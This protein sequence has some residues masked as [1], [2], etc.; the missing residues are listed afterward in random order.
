VNFLPSKDGKLL[1]FSM[2]FKHKLFFKMKKRLLSI[3]LKLTLIVGIFISS[4]L[5]VDAQS[6]LISFPNN[7]QDVTACY[8]S[9]LLTV[10]L[11]AIVN[12]T[13][14]GDV[15]ISLPNGVEYI[16]NSVTM[17]SG[18]SGISISENGGTLSAPIF[19]INPGTLNIADFIIFT[20]KRVASC[21]SYN[22]VL[23]GEIFFD[24]VTASINGVSNEVDSP[25]YNIKYP[26]LSLEQPVAQNDALL[27]N[28]N[29]AVA[30]TYTRN[31]TITNGAE[32]CTDRIYF[33][34]EYPDA[35]I[36]QITLTLAGNTISPTSISGNTY[37]YQISGTAFG[38]DTQF[39]NGETLVFTETYRIL[40]CNSITNYHA[41]WGCDATPSNWCQTSSGEGI[42]TMADGVPG[43]TGFNTQLIGYVDLCT[44]YV[45]RT[46]YTAGGTGNATASSL[47]DVQLR[48]GRY[49][50]DYYLLTISQIVNMSVGRVRDNATGTLSTVVPFVFNN[51]Y[52]YNLTNFFTSDPDG[53]GVGLEDL[54]NDGFFDDLPA[55]KSVTLDISA[56]FNCVNTNCGTS[57][58]GNSHYGFGGDILYHTMCDKTTYVP[59]KPK[60]ATP[61]R[62]M[63]A[64]HSIT[65]T[66]NMPANIEPGVPFTVRGSYNYYSEI[67][68]WRTSSSRY[69]YEFTLPAGS[70]V[71]NVKWANGLYPSGAL[72]P[73]SGYTISGNILTVTSPTSTQ[74]WTTFD[75]TYNCAAGINFSIT[76]KVLDH[77]SPTCACVQEI[78]CGTLSALSDCNPVCAQGPYTRVPRVER[79]DNSLGWTDY[80]LS[81][82]QLR[83]NISAY[84]LSK[85]LYLDEIEIKGNAIQNGPAAN[86]YLKMDLAKTASA[87]S[88]LTP[89]DIRVE[90]YRLGVLV[91][92]GT[93]STSSNTGSTPSMQ[94]IIWNLTSTLPAG[95]LLDQDEIRTLSRYQVA[96]NDGL[97]QHDVQSGNTFRFYNLD[98]FGNQLGCDPKIPEMYLVGLRRLD[99]HNMALASACNITTL[100]GNYHHIATRFDP[101]GT[102]YVNEFRP[103]GYLAKYELTVSNAYT[104]L[105]SG[106]IGISMTGIGSYTMT[107]NSI[108]GNTY[109]YLNPGTWPAYRLTVENT[110]GLYISPRFQPN[111][112]AESS[113][114]PVIGKVY[115]R[116]FYYHYADPNNTTW[117]KIYT[118]NPVPTYSNSPSIEISDQTGLIQASES[119]ETWRIQ[120]FNPSNNQAPY[121]WIAIPNTSGVTIVSVIDEATGTV[122]NGIPYSNSGGGLMYQLSSNGLSSGASKF[123][124]IN[125]SYNTCNQTNVNILAGWNC[126][127]FLTDPYGTACGPK[128][129]ITLSFVPQTAEIEITAL[130]EPV[131]PVDLCLPLHYEYQV[132]SAQ[133]GSV[134]NATFSIISSTGMTPVAGSFEAEYP[135]GAGNWESIP[136]TIIGNEYRY[137]LSAHSAYPI[138][139]LPGTL[140]D[141]GNPANRVV[142]IRFDID[143]DC[144]FVSGSNFEVRVNGNMS[145][146]QL[147]IGS[148]NKIQTSAIDVN[149][150]TTDYIVVNHLSI[151]SSSTGNFNTCGIPIT[152]QGS[153]I[154]ISG[155]ATTNSTGY[156]EIRLPEGYHYV[157]GSFNCTSSPW[158]PTFNGITTGLGNIEIVTL[159]IPSGMTSGS[160]LDYTI[161]ILEDLNNPL[162]CGN[163]TIELVSLDN[164]NNVPC[165]SA[166]GGQCPSIDIET[167]HYDLNFNLQKAILDVNIN[168]VNSS[169]NGTNETLTVGFTLNNTSSTAV[170]PVGT[171]VEIFFDSNSNGVFD[172]TD[173]FIDDEIIPSQINT[174]ASF[175]GNIIF[176]ASPLQVCNLLLVVD[177]NEN[178]CI[179]S[180]NFEKV[181]SPINLNNIAGSDQI[182]C[183]NSTVTL[184]TTS[185]SNY[186]YIWTGPTSF[187]SSTSTAQPVFAYSG[188]PLLINT[189]FT[190]TLNVTRPNGCSSS[191][192]VVITVK[193]APVG[194]NKSE[195]ICSGTTL[196]HNLNNDVT[197]SGNT[198]EWSAASNPNV[199]GESTSTQTTGNITDTLV[200]T[201]NTPQIVV[202][203]ITPTGS[204]ACP[205]NSFTYSVTVNPTP[206][207]NSISNQIVCK[208]TSTS[209]ITFSGTISGT[210]Y[211][212][213]NDTTSIGLAASGTG[214]IASF[215]AT[216]T[217]TAPVTATI[218]VTPHFANGGT[219]CDGTAQTFTI[220]VNPTAQVN[221]PADQVVCN[222]QSTT[223]VNFT[224]NNTGGT[225]TYTWTNDTTSIG[226]AASGT[227]NIASFT[228]T[229][230]TTAPVTA[231]IT[232][233]P[234]YANGGTTCDG[235]AQTFTITVNPTAQ[236]NDPADQVVCNGQS[237]TAVNFTTNNTG[238]TTTYTWTND[239]TSIGL[240]ASGT[241]NIALFTATNTTTAPVT[242]TITVTPHYANGGTTCDGTAQTFTITVNPTAQVNDPADQVVCNGQSTTAV[243]FTTNNTGG[244]TT[245]TWTNDTTSIGLAAS[246]TG[247]I[248]SF[249]ATNTTTAPV[250]ATITVTP[251]YA[252]GGTTCDGTAQTFTITVNPTAQ[253][254]DPADQVV[255][256]G[257]STTAVNFT[258]NNTGG[259]T[260]YTWTNDTT[261]IGLAASG[262]GN[263]AS[264]T[265]T[266][267]TTAPV[268]ATI[269]VT[270]HYANGG[271]TCDGTA[272][273]FTI[274]VNPTAQVNDPA[275]QVVCNG[276]STTAVNFTTNNTGG[277]TTYTW[278]NNTTSI[279]LAASGTGNI[280]SF[281]ATNTTTAPVT[282][283][284]TVTPHYANGGTTCDGTAQTFTI[285]VNPTAQVNDPADQVV[286]NGQSTTAVNFTTNNTGGTTTYTWTNDTTSIGL[287]ASGTGNIA[288]FTATNTT[289]APVTAT[290][291]V[292]P[293]YANGGTTCDGTAQTFTITVNPTAQVNDPADQVVCNGQSTTAVNF[294]T[295]N[296]GGTT[297]Y[298]W[299][300]DT[301]SIGLAASGTGNIASF[302]ATNTTTAPVTATITVTPHY[303][304][305]GT[306][307]DGTAQTFTITVNPTAQVNDP[308][309][310]VVCNGQS[311]TAVNFTTNN[312]GGTTTY[313]WTNDTTS[314]GLAASGTGSIASFTA[315]NTTTAPV[316]AT[317]TVTPHYANGGTTCDGTVQTFTITVN[318]TAQV[319]DPADQVVC[320]GQSTTAV[321]FTTNNTGGTTTYTWTNDTTSIGLAASGTGNIA[322]F[323]ATNTTTAPVT[324]T[325]TVTPHYA[326]GGATCDGTA[327]TFTITVNPTAQVNDPADQ[328]VC[329]GQSTTAVNFT[330]NNTGGTTT[331]TWTNNTTSIGLAASGTGNIASFTAT[332]TTTAPVTATITV[333]PHYANGG[334]TCDGTA[335]TF[336]I[337]VNP[338]AQ[339]NDP[340][341][342][343][344]CNGQS[345]TAVNFT[346]NNT[347]GTTTY[348]WTNDTTSIGLAASGTG[349]IASFTATNTTT[350]PVTA[351]IT[352]TPHYANGGTTCDGTAQTFTITVNPT[353]Q[354]NDPA[355]QVVCNGQSTTAVNFTTNNT[356]GTTTYTWTNDTTSIGLAASGT[357]N[358]AS[359]TATNTTTAPVTATITVTPHYANGGT[360]CDG[361]AQTFTIT[362]NPT[363]Q[364][365][366]P[367]DQVVCNGQSTTAVNFTT[368]NTGGTTTYTWTN[369]TTSIGLA[370]SGT[371][372]IASFTATNTT[373]APVTATITVT[374]HYAN[375]G[376]TCDGT[377]QT[378]TI[379]V[380]PTAQVNDPADQVVCNGQS[381]TAVNFTTNNTGGT[382]T[383]TWT[384]DTTSIGLAASGTGSIASFTATNT[385]TAPVTA[386]ITVTPTYT[387]AGVSCTGA[388]TTFNFTVNPSAQVNTLSNQLVCNGQITT[389]VNFTTNNTGGTTTYTWTNDTTSIGLAAS[390]TGNIASFT[391][392][393]TTTAPV[394]ATITVT[395]T[396]T[397]AGV[398]CTGVSTTFT[399]TVNPE[400]VGISTTLTICSGDTLNHILSDYS[401]LNGTT[402]TWSANENINITGETT[403][404]TNTGV[405]DDTLYNLTTNNHVVLYTITT[406]SSSGC[407]GNA[408]YLTVIVK[409]APSATNQT[410][411]ICSGA[412][413]NHVLSSYTTMTGN[414][415][416][417]LAAEN[418]QVTGETTTTQTTGNIV[419][420]LVNTSGVNQEVVYTI[421][422]S[423][424]DG[425]EGAS[426]TIT[427]TIQTEPVGTNQNISICSGLNLNQ[428]LNNYTSPNGNTFSWSGGFNPNVFGVTTNTQFTSTI[429]DTLINTT[430]VD[431]V[432]V[433]TITPTSSAGCEGA[434]FTVTVTIQSEPVGT[435]QMQTICSDTTLNHVL[436][437]Y[438]TMTGNTYSWVAASNANVTGETTTVQTTSSITDTLTNTTLV[439]QTVVYTI[440]PTSS[441][442]CEGNPYTYTVTVNPEPVGTNATETVCS[443][444][445]LNHDLTTDTTL[446]GN[447]YSWVA[448]SNANVTGET[449]TVQ[450]TSSITDTL[451]NTTLVAQ[452]VVYTITPTSSNGCEGNPYT[453]TVTVN[454]EPVGTNATE[455]VCSDVALNHDLTTDT[456]LTGNTYSWVAASNANVTG[457]TTTVQTTSS[458][459]D[460]LTNTTLVAQT[461]VYTIT[462]TS[463]NGCEGNPY[464]YTVTVNPEPVGTNATETICSDVALN[465]DLTTDTTLTGNTYSWVAASNANV[466]GETTTVQTTSSITDT[467]TNTTLVAQTVVY[468]ITPTSSNGCE[469]NPY[470]YT[471]TVNPE[472]V[473]TNATETVCSD[474]ALNHDLTTDTTLTGN[475][476]S[477]VAASNANVTGE[478]TT[479]QTTSSITDTLTNT[480]LVAQT[481][482]YTITPTSSNGCEGNPY[483][484]T[485]TVNPEPVGTNATET[486]CSDVALNHDLTTD[487]TLTGNTY[488]WVAAS[489]ANV[490]G[491]T[492]TVQTTSS[493]TDTLTNT[494]L[495]AQTVVYTITPTSSNG[496]EGN[497]YTYTVTVNPEPVG[498]NATETVCSDVALN[499]DLTT[500]TTLTGNTYSWVAASNANVTG[501]TTTVQTTSSITDT[502]T[503]TTL[504]AQTVVYT[505]TP[506]S[507][508]GCEGNPYTY[509]VTVNPEPV[510]TNATETVCSDVALNHDLT[511]DTTLTGNTYSWVAASNANVTGETTTVQT[512][513]S[514]T[515]TLTNTTLV[516]QTV[517]YT[518]TPT[519]SNGCEGNPYTYTVTVNP[520][521]VGTNATETVCSDVALNHDL[522]TDTTL[523]GNTYSWVAASNANVTGETTT[524]QT[525]SSITDT[526]T[527]TSGVD[528]VV[529]YT[530]TP[531]S[532]AGCL[533]TSFTFTVTIQ[534][535]P[536]GTAQTQTICSGSTLNQVLSS[537]TTM[538]GN[539]YT[540]LATENV[541]VTGETITT[542]TTGSIT[543]TLVNTSGVNQVVVYTIT[544][545]SNTGCEGSSF[546][547]TV[548]IQSEPV[549]TA[550]TQTIC[551]GATLNHVLSGYTTMTGNTFTWSAAANGQVTGETTT[552]QT[553][554]SITDTLINNSGLD[555][556]VVYT[557]T[558]TSSAG[559]E[560]ASFT[561]TV[562]IHP[563]V[564][565]NDVEDQVLCNGFNTIATNFT[566]NLSNDTYYW[567][568]DNPLIG[569]GVNGVGNIPSFLATNLSNVPIVANISVYSQVNGCNSI[570]T[571]TFSITVNPTP[572]IPVGPSVQTFCQEILATVA[573]LDVHI[574]NGDSIVWY[575]TTTGG[576]PL[577]STDLLHN[578]FYYA[579]GVYNTGCISNER[580][581]V[582]VIIDENC[583][584]IN[585]EKTANII[586]VDAAG[587]QIIYTFTV[588]N[589]NN[590][591]LQNVTVSDALV[592][593]IVFV[594]GDLNANNLLD[595]NET[596]IYTATLTVTQAMID[597]C[598]IDATG[599]FDGDG[600]ID[601]IAIANAKT[602]AGI[603]VPS[604]QDDEYVLINYLNNNSPSFEVTKVADRIEV[605]DIDEVIIYTITVVN[606]SNYALAN[607][608]IDDPLLDNETYTSG[609]T[610]N[611]SM[612]DLNE[613]WIY[614][615]TFT[616]TQAILQGF[617]V[618]PYGNIDDDGTIDNIVTVYAETPCGT[619]LA[620]QQAEVS[621]DIKYIFIPEGF[622]PDGDNYNDTFEI[623]GV[624]V[625]YPD[626]TLEIYNRWGNIVYD[627]SN[628]GSATPQWWDGISG[629]RVTIVEEDGVPEGTYY[630]ILDPNNGVDEPIVNWVFVNRK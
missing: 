31:F 251:H 200:N 484:Y 473:G 74:G 210:T 225:T 228:A 259:T 229:N 310:Q 497:P 553:T 105:N 182:I 595:V 574:T 215:T 398:S 53:V 150:I 490:T 447:T 195:T 75:I 537:Y 623:S 476:Y 68:D 510:G 346:T 489:N 224:T 581:V 190:F 469:G 57:Y 451:T 207:V 594:S 216:N 248:A 326:N 288:S 458:I 188:A 506:T 110:Y 417:W 32:G 406:N 143:T 91:S 514:I 133:S 412:T 64:R 565:I 50:Y 558:P 384:N 455:T 294:T 340:A 203:T 600:D 414:T 540:W 84:D 380:N 17:I 198:F 247:N 396:Y 363:A 25:P 533:G 333:T 122:I 297:T 411:N 483:T 570:N 191:D 555:Q 5:K 547:I 598:G 123:Y 79:A 272:Q 325:I 307:C 213:T 103:G 627:Y 318:P 44:P 551:S 159:L 367:A 460:T 391:A 249:T 239:T 500:D 121:T 300:N 24:K 301:T 470:T 303:A 13:T 280:A 359:F 437:S 584:F 387:N 43:L 273:T 523:T 107:P 418:A 543:D 352:V 372:N 101:S 187:L 486:V 378:F 115:L 602:M 35:G 120:M 608:S 334:T 434:S 266:N 335:Q 409:P 116:D 339:V 383:Y 465:H 385:T 283:T 284:I 244:T 536:V 557:I 603:S 450:T 348:T 295:N 94:N 491:E 507:S 18:T 575:E 392:T 305:G 72:S 548:T 528:Q 226:L 162:D 382:T 208:G 582:Q 98:A 276:Q 474:V 161:Q 480:T 28:P 479:V 358:I 145:C 319:N 467:L 20:L 30:T 317:I 342:Q 512:T 343:V 588:T 8:S 556:V 539:T 454:P 185:N 599:A 362:V 132:N 433:Y 179:C 561:I 381:T 444:V 246:G 254:N 269:T 341:D 472:P 532:S 261:S 617:G 14:G 321:N 496:C 485:V 268:T 374:P 377:A 461:V 274:T 365:N 355:D 241:G 104:L 492:T 400:S 164:I 34:I 250:T 211:T 488:S 330:T 427:V 604:A 535:E 530:I 308:A 175:S 258:T 354:V 526:L 611:N 614:T 517:V 38:T 290:I 41:G 173:V 275:D 592:P 46:T 240:A 403:T 505:I 410:Q 298:T 146:G 436:S 16:P 607:V 361:T 7:P 186:S 413:L 78:A 456:T 567:T 136:V 67:N 220:T 463:S 128:D 172:P 212:W 379:T 149:G 277:T 429:T 15:M 231:T 245:Y 157:S 322:S 22:N 181:P 360:T 501:E 205:G 89:L 177:R 237:T 621:V 453:Y 111:C 552:N 118:W 596:W 135:I 350:A 428:N 23:N 1:Y 612:L 71:S 424:S 12:S 393:N 113:T 196:S 431:Q 332:N 619:S 233:T 620:S 96:V 167:G 568:N 562:T 238:G 85:A 522:T 559:C 423:S 616:C 593:N 407:A 477:W 73:Y 519:S 550:Q 33:S 388:S 19:K 509:T 139:G 206:T 426:F 356:G 124:K 106:N 10:R 127:G 192:E 534:S 201:T 315:T 80:T 255:C 449:T 386:T 408:F 438:T 160:V 66:G 337:T 262:T 282:A 184:G 314:I 100:G 571:I 178:P 129:T 222:G 59:T 37:F 119:V 457:E 464:T 462:P 323:T 399:I 235:T 142:K 302:T 176:N 232:V 422:P 404:Q 227:G 527:N 432:V 397:N 419:D 466:T 193:P 421:T 589:I 345:T 441:N 140:N 9:E 494:T 286:C 97:I 430:G 3:S 265:A 586:E 285:T 394:T 475:T 626:F 605:R 202:Y 292:T 55:G 180:T 560:G 112:A 166:P 39:C 83:S 214:N 601:N 271:A 482:V 338:T 435:A 395:P 260:T 364:V 329:N 373:T 376:T 351:T 606:T 93:V 65:A 197:L 270:P 287:A 154:I 624:E 267:T 518:I 402:F 516:A 495:V 153:E 152:L 471:V 27:Y 256:N 481:V 554:G 102:N 204:N 349:N 279:G 440:T 572:Q 443:D 76:Y 487:T 578:G 625:V 70:T 541:Q 564:M 165:W 538:T 151:D 591:P 86:L 390:G 618:D 498:T 628:N 493:I 2:L 446:T 49:Y 138:G 126:D 148:G 566:S 576:V 42:V 92:S 47:Y 52:N 563:Q 613:T 513:S 508:N 223:A 296:T 171:V 230:T 312:T 545:T 577:N 573:N 289:T 82:R 615:G 117:E 415:Y 168:T 531:T 189:N 48:I 170:A 521:P 401:T 389:A 609:D 4:I 502:L 69:I 309:D 218:T 368:N 134:V 242:A 88:K 60:Q 158:C 327:Q 499:H 263:I 236:V 369:N 520:E 299:T 452:T 183:A 503:N 546:T 90:I 264:F 144:N 336:T 439:A 155:G 137:N 357:G 622:S 77:N 442:G 278:T 234:H 542:Q 147:A 21:E 313:T 217:T 597:N 40:K 163:N 63:M 56:S 353:A 174:S 316:T 580:L 579:E 221:D 6:F 544:P 281:T 36:Q 445:A 304:N 209:P 194:T 569:L 11:D 51:F 630:Y 252:N 344:V 99:G 291:T 370:A 243:N 58:T 131:M 610:N 108:V 141:G 324:A 26:S 511:T 61:F 629:G 130:S 375:G 583:E 109:T 347:G 425:C 590:Y 114:E 293:H 504:V 125:F 420:T 331:Y 199:N 320:N 468:T 219:T 587:D 478:T 529:V 459:T 29:N 448:A 525:T 156:I 416:T 81:T 54:D 366:D 328:V 169:V 524:V 549:G 253:V 257:Q 371:G 405:I 95:G 306:T 515:D 45:M 311:T 585:I 87:V 62:G